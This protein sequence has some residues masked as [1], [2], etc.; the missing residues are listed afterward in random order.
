M[1]LEDV[2]CSKTTIKILKT[3]MRLGQLNVSD[4]AKHVGANFAATHVRLR[5]LESEGILQQRTSGR[6]KYFRL[7]EYSP[8]AKA[9][10]FL[11]EAWEKDCNNS[12]GR[13][14]Q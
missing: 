5:L 6:A 1:N 14:P 13:K 4:T 2:L 10:Q 12:S 9:L 8:R 11:I 3:I 7:R